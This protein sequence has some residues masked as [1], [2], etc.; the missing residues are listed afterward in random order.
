MRL[1]VNVNTITFAASINQY[2]KGN[3]FD[4]DNSD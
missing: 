3:D 1:E 2:H 4:W